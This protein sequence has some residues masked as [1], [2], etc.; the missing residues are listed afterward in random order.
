MLLITLNE[1]FGPSREAMHR[2]HVDPK[3]A[4]TE[5]KEYLTTF[6]TR[7]PQLEA[8]RRLMEYQRAY[9]KHYWQVTAINFRIHAITEVEDIPDDLLEEFQTFLV[10]RLTI[11]GEDLLT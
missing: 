6:A 11:D 4:K 7:L 10:E 2:E 3:A 8:L 5:A 9:N 1:W